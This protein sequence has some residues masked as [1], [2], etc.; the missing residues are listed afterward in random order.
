MLLNFTEQSTEDIN[1]Q[2]LASWLWHFLSIFIYIFPWELWFKAARNEHLRC[3][4]AKSKFVHWEH[5]VHAH[6]LF[7]AD[8]KS[9]A[10][11]KQAP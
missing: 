8:D 1:F 10:C 11:V 7:K 9:K 3:L 6:I 5:P 2:Q 4:G